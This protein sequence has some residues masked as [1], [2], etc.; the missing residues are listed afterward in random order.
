MGK[1]LELFLLLI[2]CAFVQVGCVAVHA[3]VPDTLT[4]TPAAWDVT[5]PKTMFLSKKGQF[6][7]A[8]PFK[9]SDIEEGVLSD[10]AVKFQWSATAFEKGSEKHW[11]SFT[12]AKNSK[13]IAWVACQFNYQGSSYGKKNSVLT[14]KSSDR[15]CD[16]KTDKEQFR[17]NAYRKELGLVSLDGNDVPYSVSFSKGV[18]PEQSVDIK[19]GIEFHTLSK[20]G[21]LLAWFKTLGDGDPFH[22]RITPKISVRD[23]AAAV[24]TGFAFFALQHFMCDG[25][26]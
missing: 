25:G 3:K 12:V 23:E 10:V 18:V 20:E 24:G 9:T 14:M 8:G 1:H 2:T 7:R 22:M 21:K 16:I 11:L 17:L 13:T 15:S 5:P 19:T 4:D 26:C 6:F